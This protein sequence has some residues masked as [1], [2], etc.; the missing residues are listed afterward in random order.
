MKKIEQRTSYGTAQFKLDIC[1]RVLV[2]L[3]KRFGVKLASCA[4]A[5]NSSS[6]IRSSRRVIRS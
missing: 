5:H 4:Q 3:L 2:E 1:T 6:A